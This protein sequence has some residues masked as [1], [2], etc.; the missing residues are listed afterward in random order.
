MGAVARKI[1]DI[2]R[3]KFIQ[4]AYCD[5]KLRGNSLVYVIRIAERCNQKKGYCWESFE[6]M[7]KGLGC[8]AGGIYKGYKKAESLGWVIVLKRG[9]RGSGHSYHVAP[10]WAK[11]KVAIEINFTTEKFSNDFQ[12]IENPPG[13]KFNGSK[14]LHSKDEKLHFEKKKLHSSE[15]N[16]II[17]SDLEKEPLAAARPATLAAARGGAIEPNKDATANNGVPDIPSVLDR[18]TKAK[19]GLINQEEPASEFKIGMTRR[20]NNSSR[21]YEEWHHTSAVAAPDEGATA[22]NN[23]EPNELQCR[24]NQAVANA[25]S[26]TML[27]ALIAISMNDCVLMLKAHSR[28]II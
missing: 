22:N 17:K 4:A 27:N 18:L 8:S 13:V 14:K 1:N 12:E 2:T 28:L 7:A 23:G 6:E 3:W 21:S 16:L 5:P 25:S 9:K 11:A 19:A 15:E 20:S 26:A 10:N 24:F